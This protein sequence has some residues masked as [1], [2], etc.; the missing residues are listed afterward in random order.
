M[1]GVG[2]PLILTASMIPWRSTFEHE[3]LYTVYIRLSFEEVVGVALEHRFDIGFVALQHEGASANGAL[4]L[5]QI[6][7]LLHNFRGNNPRACRVGQHM[8]QPDKR[9]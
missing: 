2:S 8:H 1:A 4:R 5:L 6:A 3:P 9:L 7:K